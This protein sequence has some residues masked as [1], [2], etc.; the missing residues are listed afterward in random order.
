MQSADDAYYEA[1]LLE[2]LKQE[3]SFKE[4]AAS[5]TVARGLGRSIRVFVGPPNSGKT[6]A[7]FEALAAAP[8]G[9]YLA[10]LRLLALEGRDSLAGRGVACDLLTGEDYEPSAADGEATHTSSTIEMLHQTRVV[11]VCIVDEAQ[12]LHDQR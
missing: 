8:T 11:D 3:L 2:E 1:E 5:F 6:F 10:P 9:V 12:M 7:A 4:F